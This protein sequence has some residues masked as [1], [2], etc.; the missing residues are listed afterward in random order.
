LF[1]D[2]PM[3]LSSSTPSLSQDLSGSEGMHRLA[4]NK[5]MLI[6]L[7][8][9]AGSGKTDGAARYLV[10]H[11]GY[12]AF[13]F[14]D[15]LKELLAM[16]F[17][18]SAEQ[19]HGPLKEVP[20]PR[21]G[22]SPRWYM[23]YLG[24]N[25]FKRLYPR[26]WIDHL[27]AD[28]AAFRAVYPERPA[29]VTDVRFRDEAEALKKLDGVL[30]RLERAGTGAPGGIPRHISETELDT[31]KGWDYV[32]DNNGDLNTLHAMLDRITGGG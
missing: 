1:K 24:T 29:V 20:D 7:S 19:L 15:H 30:I 4:M 5:P 12:R 25:V 2:E 17:D 9:K 16:V 13:A 6:G 3:N 14:A 28:L 23:Q 27:E 18:F 26:I 8:G 31:W 22:K 21:L 32:I 10:E 11:Y